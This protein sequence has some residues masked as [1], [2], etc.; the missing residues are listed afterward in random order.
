M[1]VTNIIIDEIGDNPSALKIQITDTLSSD[2]DIYGSA[3]Y[4]SL[5]TAE[6]ATY[7]AF[8]AL[9]LSKLPA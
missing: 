9:C 1:Q 7:D 8:K 6:K 2:P 4:D 3:T 5:T